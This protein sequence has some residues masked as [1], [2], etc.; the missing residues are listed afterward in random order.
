[1]DGFYQ[2]NHL[3]ERESFCGHIEFLYADKVFVAFEWV[4]DVYFVAIFDSYI[5]GKYRETIHA[6]GKCC[7]GNNCGHGDVFDLCVK[8]LVR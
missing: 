6:Q 5:I 7:H 8:R 1:M 3:S 4:L 2:L